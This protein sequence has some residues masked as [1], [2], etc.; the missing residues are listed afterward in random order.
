MNIATAGRNGSVAASFPVETNDQIMLVTDGGK[1]IRSPIADIRIAG[2]STQG[3]TLFDT[4]QNEKV[5]SVAHLRESDDPEDEINP[6]NSSP[7]VQV[8]GDGLTDKNS[9]DDNVE[10]A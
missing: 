10:E 8:Q 3:V 9:V 5:V 2:R 7:D 1:I 6:L 4:A